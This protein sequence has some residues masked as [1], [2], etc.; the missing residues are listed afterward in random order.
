VGPGQRQG[1][2]R[3]RLPSLADARLGNR[4]QVRSWTQVYSNTGPGITPPLAQ[5][6][7]VR[8][9]RPQQTERRRLLLCLGAPGLHGATTAAHQP[10]L[11][12]PSDNS[13]PAP[14]RHRLPHQP[15]RGRR[16]GRGAGSACRRFPRLPLFVHDPGRADHRLSLGATDEGGLARRPQTGKWWFVL[17]PYR[18]ASRGSSM[19]RRPPS[20]LAAHRPWPTGAGSRVSGSLKKK[21]GDRSHAHVERLRRSGYCPSCSRR[22]GSPGCVDQVYCGSQGGV[23]SGQVDLARWCTAVSACEGPKPRPAAGRGNTQG[24]RPLIAPMSA[25]LVFDEARSASAGS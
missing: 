17:R 2:V 14:R 21:G 3:H 16:S 1:H 22:R 15:R 24:P 23:R 25:G 10:L 13:F 6:A 5:D 19:P 18:A 7:S 11:S 8:R 4:H 20:A 9:L 12:T